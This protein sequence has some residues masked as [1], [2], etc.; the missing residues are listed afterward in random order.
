MYMVSECDAVCKEYSKMVKNRSKK[1]AKTWTYILLA[2]IV[3]LILLP[4]VPNIMSNETF[5]L[6]YIIYGSMILVGLIIGVLVSTFSISDKPAFD[7][8]YKEVYNKLNQE[9]GTFYEYASYEKEKFEFNSR[10]GIFTRFCRSEVKRHVSG[11]SSNGNN[12]NIFDVT[13]V[14]GGGKNRHVHFTGIYYVIKYSSS[15]I[16]QIRSHSKPHLKG[17]KLIKDNDIQEFKVFLEEGQNTSNIQY[18]FI[19]T[20]ERLKRNLSAKKIFL[21]ITNDELHFAYIP[22]VH[23]RKQYDLNINKLNK[24]YTQFLEELRVVD[25]LLETSEF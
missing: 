2:F 9:R 17:V 11:I 6:L 13:L 7:Y 24:I 21:G 10:G 12:F 18:K 16:F 3:I 14:T 4:F 23:I 1:L 19:E 22:K 25:E 8:L 5:R 20:I 15:I